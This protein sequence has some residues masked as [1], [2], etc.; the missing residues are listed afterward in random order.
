MNKLAGEKLRSVT[1]GASF[2]AA[3][4]P[5]RSFVFPL[6]EKPTA[7]NSSSTPVGKPSLFVLRIDFASLALFSPLFFCY[8]VLSCLLAG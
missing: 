8:S 1:P 3:S 4:Q 6:R 7:G 2:A 5:A